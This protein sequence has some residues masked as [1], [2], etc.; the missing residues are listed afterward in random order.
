METAIF[1]TMKKASEETNHV[2]NLILDFYLQKCFNFFPVV[3]PPRLENL[4]IEILINNILGNLLEMKSL[5]VLSYS[6][7]QE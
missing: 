6:E 5:E 2:S 1:K 7:T 4:F 3:K